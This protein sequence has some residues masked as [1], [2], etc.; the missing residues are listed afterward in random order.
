[1]KNESAWVIEAGSPADYWTG[2]TWS[3]NIQDAIR[4]TREIDAH[5]GMKSLPAMY[6]DCKNIRAAGHIWINDMSEPAENDVE[7]VAAINQAMSVLKKVASFDHSE[8]CNY[9]IDQDDDDEDTDLDDRC[10]CLIKE[11]L[12]AIA[13][14]QSVDT[15]DVV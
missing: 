5:R 4:Y 3:P 1:M 14:M 11:S 6:R 7:R 12:D 15:A 2:I 9:W 13:A 8:D 10:D